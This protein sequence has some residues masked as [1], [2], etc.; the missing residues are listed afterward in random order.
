MQQV[1]FAEHPPLS[2]VLTRHAGYGTSVGCSLQVPAISQVNSSTAL[3]TARS[4]ATL[5]LCRRFLPKVGIRRL[6]H[7]H[8]AAF[9][10]L[11][12]RLDVHLDAVLTHTHRERERETKNIRDDPQE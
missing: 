10:V 6:L 5:R 11:R 3:P 4:R 1:E 2:S 12:G 9:R 7:L 8:H